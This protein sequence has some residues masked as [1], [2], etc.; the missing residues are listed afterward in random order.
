MSAVQ[1][2]NSKE[3][4]RL[5]RFAAVGGVGTLIDFG[6]LILLK[7]IGLPTLMANTLSYSMGIVNNYALNRLWTFPDSRSKP[8]MTQFAQFAM[9]S[10][11]G[12]AFNNL[13]VLLLE[14]PLGRLF[15]TPNSGYVF[16]K[17]FATV[18]VMLWNFVANRLW[19]F[20]D[21]A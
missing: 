11:L 5:I 21:V 19:T 3:T 15:G 1:V 7:G 4:R 18:L 14:A 6:G 13:L 10:L 20:N 16:A 12:L 9:I 17:V 2:L 8:A